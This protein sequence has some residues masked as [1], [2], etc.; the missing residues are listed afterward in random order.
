MLAAMCA[1]LE[2]EDSEVTMQ[3][4]S[5]PAPSFDMLG[6]EL[7]VGATVFVFGLTAQVHMA[8]GIPVSRR[9]RPAVSSC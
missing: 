7:W 4:K 9:S 8:A 2:A 1:Q 3:P 6:K 5:A